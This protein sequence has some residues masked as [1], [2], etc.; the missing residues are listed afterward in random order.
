MAAAARPA[1]PM[2][3]T[4]SP[5]WSRSRPTSVAMSSV[6]SRAVPA[7]EFSVQGEH[8]LRDRPP[9][10]GELQLRL[11]GHALLCGL[12]HQHFLVQAPAAQGLGGVAGLL[13]VEAKLLRVRA[14][15]PMS[16]VCLAVKPS[17]YMAIE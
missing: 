13:N 3:T 6:T 9:D 8:R 16:P 2:D 5:G 4:P 14:V 12:P 1:P 10:P 11:A 15:Q 7:T 17:S